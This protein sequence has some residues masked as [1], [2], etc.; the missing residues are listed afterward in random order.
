MKYFLIK[1]SR[2]YADEFDTHGVT[3]RTS[4]SKEKLKQQI[5]DDFEEYGE[6][7]YFGSNECHLIESPQELLGAL[8]IEE[9]TKE[10]YEVFLKYGFNHF[11]MITF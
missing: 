1:E 10:E 2:D 5:T 6:E 9:I 3:V 4:E 11:G 7:L 8:Q